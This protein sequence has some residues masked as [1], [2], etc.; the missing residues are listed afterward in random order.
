MAV[1]VLALSPGA[2]RAANLTG[3]RLEWNEGI[4][5]LM[6]IF[7]GEVKY[8]YMTLANPDRLVVDIPDAHWQAQLVADQGKAG[9]VN[10]IRHGYFKPG[11]LRVVADLSQAVT[12]K[13]FSRQDAKSN[14]FYLA[15]DMP[16]VSGGDDSAKA[17]D[18]VP[19]KSDNSKKPPLYPLPQD[20]PSPP[21]KN[22]KPII[23]LDPGHGGHDSGAISRH[24][25][26]EKDITLS[27]A[28]KIRDALMATG[29]YQV[30]LTRDDDSFLKLRERI[31]FAKKKGGDLF[32]SLHADS[33]PDRETRGFSV[34]TLS[35]SASDKE[36]EMLAQ[37]E[38]RADVLSNVDLNDQSKEV[39]GM[40][41]ELAQRDTM[42]K[43]AELA[44]ALV[45]ELTYEEIMGLR[46][47]H[48]S[49][50]FAVLKSPDIPSVLI[51][52]GFLTNP[53]DERQLRSPG[54]EKRLANSV[55]AGVD[56]YFKEVRE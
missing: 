30:Y 22:K 19:Q 4:I 13:I 38:N 47:T 44:R 41:I 40:L 20:K 15:I 53:Q 42:N 49:A 23:V 9:V 26:M 45:A 1:V 56:R 35:D 6:L 24:D 39:A 48:R 27:Y 36:A 34:Y 21:D 55:A 54:F 25:V 14:I 7:D 17:A 5:R 51:E 32:I 16:T 2:G 29:H 11:E 37:R 8:S 12:P 46:N 52:M 10:G 3:T 33:H 43:S 50:G 31:A 28:K 18:N